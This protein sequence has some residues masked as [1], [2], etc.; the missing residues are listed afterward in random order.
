MNGAI[1]L[2][3]LEGKLNTV[4]SNLESK[5][6]TTNTNISAVKT[7][8]DN[9]YS[10]VDTEIASILTNTNTN[11][12]ASVTGTLS[13]KLSY[14]ANNLIGATNNTGGSSSAGTIMAKLNALVGISK[15]KVTTGSFTSET[16]DKFVYKNAPANA[17]FYITGAN[18]PGYVSPSIGMWTTE[19]GVKGE[20][21]YE[22]YYTTTAR[23]IQIQFG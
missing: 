13:Q 12:T 16:T 11:N 14:I 6:N 10:K 5:I 2:D 1:I 8:V 3:E 17:I 15:I 4:N 18:R 20:L 7:V 21:G 9:I 22:E 19:I 23:Y